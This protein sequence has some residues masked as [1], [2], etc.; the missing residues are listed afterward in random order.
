MAKTASFSF[1][2]KTA[3]TYKTISLYDM[4]ELTNYGKKVTSSRADYLNTQASSPDA[5]EKFTFY[6]G[7]VRSVPCSID[8]AYPSQKRLASKDSN[9]KI[10]EGV[11]YGILYEAILTETDSSDPKYRVDRPVRIQLDMMH[12]DAGTTTTALLQEVL[13]RVYSLLETAAGNSRIPELRGGVVEISS[14]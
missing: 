8:V 4:G 6:S 10:N 3:T 12:E 2:N 5:R 14:N 1:T 13:G 11:K 7:A 9:S